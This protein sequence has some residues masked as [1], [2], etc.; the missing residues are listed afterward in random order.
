MN[1][2]SAAIRIARL[3]ITTMTVAIRGVAT[4]NR[5]RTVLR[6]RGRILRRGPTRRRAAVIRHRA[7]GTP[8]QAVALVEGLAVAVLRRAAVIAEG[9]V[10]SAAAV[11]GAQAMAAEEDRVTEAEV[12]R[13][14]ATN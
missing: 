8:R 4:R 7:V 14:A 5:D 10:P 2:R 13:T 12:L 9:V 6:N 1:R 3:Q 11:V